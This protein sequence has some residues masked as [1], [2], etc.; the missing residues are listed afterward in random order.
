MIF[1][2]GEFPGDTNMIWF[3]SHPYL[4]FALGIFLLSV[5]NNT[6]QGV[7]DIFR[8]PKVKT[9]EES[10]REEKPAYNDSFFDPNVH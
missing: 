5:V 9:P 6:I 4:T 2:G 3:L 8:N 7:L 1:H 10:P